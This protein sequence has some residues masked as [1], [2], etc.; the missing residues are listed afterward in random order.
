MVARRLKRPPK[1]SAHLSTRRTQVSL[2]KAVID[3]VAGRVDQDV[4]VM[5][6]ETEKDDKRR[7]ESRGS[8]DVSGFEN[9]DER[10]VEDDPEE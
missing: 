3:R 2:A 7:L 5:P 6:N 10:D 4:E 8:R 1:E 9:L